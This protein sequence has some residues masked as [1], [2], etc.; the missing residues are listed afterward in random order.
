[1]DIEISKARKIIRLWKELLLD[2]NVIT[3]DRLSNMYSSNPFKVLNIAFRGQIP[4]DGCKA[5]WFL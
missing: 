2:V 4:M 3:N 1:M 5:T